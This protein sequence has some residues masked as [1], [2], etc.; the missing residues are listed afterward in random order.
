MN[1]SSR[2]D[3]GHDMRSQTN[4]VQGDYAKVIIVVYNNNIQVRSNTPG[5]DDEDHVDINLK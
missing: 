5:E 1:S 3:E 4:P 2:D